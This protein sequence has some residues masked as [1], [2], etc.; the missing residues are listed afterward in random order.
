MLAVFLPF[1]VHTLVVIFYKRLDFI[2]FSVTNEGHWAGAALSYGSQT[3]SS[4]AVVVPADSGSFDLYLDYDTEN[5]KAVS[6][7]AIA[8]AGGS[9]DSF[10]ALNRVQEISFVADWPQEVGVNIGFD[11]D[12][13]I[14]IHTL[15]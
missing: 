10:C 14:P 4:G 9:E 3:L 5:I 6:V 15:A 1:V 2:N 8:F 11:D 12:D 7:D 13:Q